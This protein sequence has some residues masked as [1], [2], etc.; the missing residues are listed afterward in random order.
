VRLCPALA[1]DCI[2]VAFVCM[3]QWIFNFFSTVAID[4]SS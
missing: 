2:W 3:W 1:F 4:L